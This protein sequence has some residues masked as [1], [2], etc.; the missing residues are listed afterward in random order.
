M[1]KQVENLM[2]LIIEFITKKCYG[3]IAIKMEA[4][5]IVIVKKTESI[6]V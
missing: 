6:K 2:K 3:E 4:G 1:D 5:H